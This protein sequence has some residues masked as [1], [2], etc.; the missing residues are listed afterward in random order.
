MKPRTLPDTEGGM[1]RLQAVRALI[2]NHRH[3]F[4]TKLAVSAESCWLRHRLVCHKLSLSGKATGAYLP[5][6]TKQCTLEI[7]CELLGVHELLQLQ[8]FILNLVSELAPY[9]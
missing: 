5:I 9:R 1:E 4:N 3:C 8:L 2:R 6:R 7:I